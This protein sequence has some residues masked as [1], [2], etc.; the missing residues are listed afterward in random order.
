MEKTETNEERI[1]SFLSK[2]THGSAEVIEN[3]TGIFRLH[4]FKSLKSLAAAGKVVVDSSEKPVVYSLAKDQPKA[5]KGDE[6]PKKVSEEEKG[7]VLDMPER[8]KTKGR[9]TT[10]YKFQGKAYGKGPL[11][12]AVVTDYVT[13]RKTTLAKLKEVFPD[14][15]L[16]PRY[17]TVQLVNMAKKLSVGRDRFFLKPEQQIKIGDAKVAVCNQWSSDNFAKFLKIA[18][19]LGYSIK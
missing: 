2:F 4:V 3:G 7:E 6:N 8:Y 9:D 14:E 19:K 1:L 18:R 12:L 17:S 5:I 13:K 15:V 11:V 16:Q 10:K